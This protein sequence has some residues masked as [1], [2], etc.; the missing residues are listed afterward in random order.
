MAEGL[1]SQNT[2]GAGGRY[3]GLSKELG[4]KEIPAIGF[5]LGIERLL[6]SLESQNLTTEPK[7]RVEI[8]AIDETAKTSA[9]QIGHAI[10]STLPQ[11]QVDVQFGS[12]SLKAALRSS[13]KNQAT[14]VC[15]LGEDEIAKAQVQVKN[16]IQPGIKNFHLQ[17]TN[18]SRK[19]RFSRKSL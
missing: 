3:D 16:L 4:E 5:A 9:F 10:R 17:I 14:W 2:V 7:N 1:G 12:R 13:D 18:T 6:L 11:C 8:I 19:R 15:I